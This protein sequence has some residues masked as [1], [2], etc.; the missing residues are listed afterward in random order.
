MRR[1]LIAD[2][3]G[4]SGLDSEFYLVDIKELRMSRF[5]DGGYGRY[6]I[7]LYQF[8]SAVMDERNCVRLLNLFN[9]ERVLGR[10]P[11][12]RLYVTSLECCGGVCYRGGDYVLVFRWYGSVD[13][14]EGDKLFYPDMWRIFEINIR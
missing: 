13:Y 11:K 12:S 2:D 10:Y 6:D 5:L 9:K 14:I 7:P 8:D 4:V 3:F 1:N